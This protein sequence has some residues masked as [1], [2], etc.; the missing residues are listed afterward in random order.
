MGHTSANFEVTSILRM[1]RW[2]GITNLIWQREI[3]YE[4]NRSASMKSYKTIKL[5]SL[6]FDYY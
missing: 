3:S 4:C 1:K 6:K 2:K 5:R